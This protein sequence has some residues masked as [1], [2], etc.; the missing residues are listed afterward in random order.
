MLQVPTYQ[1]NEFTGF[2]SVLLHLKKSVQFAPEPEL[3][4]WREK[5]KKKKENA[6]SF[7]C[8]IE[9]NVFVLFNFKIKESLF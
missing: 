4:T 2:F 7:S 3:K 8:D 5:V 6:Y 9:K 1:N